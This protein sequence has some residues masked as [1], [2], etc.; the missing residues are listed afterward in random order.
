MWC[1]EEVTRLSTKTWILESG[2]ATKCSQA[3]FCSYE[4]FSFLIYEMRMIIIS[5]HRVV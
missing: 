4:K 2:P 3:H 1:S 5:T